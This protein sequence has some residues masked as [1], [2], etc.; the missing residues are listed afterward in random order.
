MALGADQDSIA[1]VFYGVNMGFIYT[2]QVHLDIE[3]AFSCDRLQKYMAAVGHDRARA[4]ELYCWNVT[5]SGAFFGPIGVMEVVLRNALHNRLSAVFGPQW[6]D[7][8]AFQ[9]I[10]PR[11]QQQIQKVKDD[12]VSSGRDVITP[13]IVAELSLGFWVNLLRPGRGGIYQHALWGPALS[14]AFPRGTKRSQVSDKLFPIL[15]FRNRVAHHEPI[16]AKKPAQRYQD[17][18]D[19]VGLLAAPLVPWIEHHSRVRTIVNADPN[20]TVWMF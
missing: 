4:T 17:I 12:I 5:L 7:S 19:I 20:G 8:A 15:K 18:L 14:R 13:R 1:T 9:A 6:Y 16:F 2:A 11:F 3:A 10:D